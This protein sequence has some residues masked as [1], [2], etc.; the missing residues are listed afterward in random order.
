MSLLLAQLV[1]KRSGSSLEAVTICRVLSMNW[2][3]VVVVTGDVNWTEED[4]DGIA[5]HLEITTL[6]GLGWSMAI[7]GGG[8]TGVAA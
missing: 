5:V 2:L 6:G 3:D 4:D 7:R 1:N 8:L